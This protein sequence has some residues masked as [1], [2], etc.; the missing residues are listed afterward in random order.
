MKKAGILLHISSLPGSMG[1]GTFGKEAYN[2]VDFLYYSGQTYWQ[3]LPLGP[4]TYANSPYQSPSIYA[5][6]PLFIDLIQLKDEGL[7]DELKYFEDN[8]KVD[9]EEVIS[10]NRKI[11]DSVKVIK[12]DFYYDF[13]KDNNWVYEYASYTVLKRYHHNKPWYLWDIKYRNRN[14]KALNQFIDE[15]YDAIEKEIYIQYLFYK[16]WHQLKNYAN[17]QGI[18]IIG[19]VPIYVSYDSVEVWSNP[20]IFQLDENKYPL[21]VAGVPPDY[22]SKTGQLWGNP[23]YDWDYLKQSNYKWWLDR[24]AYAL[25]LYDVIRIDHFRGFSAYFSIPFG[26]K[27]A[28]NGKWI[29]G[30]GIDFFKEVVGLYGDERIIAE[31]LGQYDLKLQELL[32]YTNFPGMKVLQFELLDPH[33]KVNLKKI[34]KNTI[35]YTGTHDNDTLVG[36]FNHLSQSTQNKI[37][38]FLKVKSP[39]N[40]HLDIIELAYQTKAKIVI[41]PIQDF[42]GLDSEYRMNTPGKVDNNWTYRLRKDQLTNKLA[43]N[44]FAIINKH[45]RTNTL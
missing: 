34:K 37:I 24:I 19:D 12:D 9:Y 44:I 41:I 30:P 28:T 7:I 45:K 26:S 31:D 1:I 29:E 10:R 38:K 36:W 5:G 23:L 21:Q 2:F 43:N 35:V 18:K 16:Q 3:I 32:D 42:L 27:D 40:I 22:F 13:I 14:Q 8:T 17:I 4:T 33:F 39:D 6:N 20:E 11:L 25:K 15:N